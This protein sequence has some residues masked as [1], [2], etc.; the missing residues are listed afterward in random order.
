MPQFRSCQKPSPAVAHHRLALISLGL[1][2]LVILMRSLPAHS[3]PIVIGEPIPAPAIRDQHGV[4]WG[5]EPNTRSVLFS[6]SREASAIAA[7]FLSDKPGFL[8]SQQSMY[9]ADMSAMPGFITR[10]F[11]LPSLQ[12]QSF[13]VGVVLETRL[14]SDWPRDDKRLLAIRLDQGRVASLTH[15]GTVDELQAFFA[16]HP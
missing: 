8:E 6:S 2:L 14:V 13:R 16:V 15:L 12:T 4:A 3:A 7:A 10:N 5:V 9:L 11:A 1:L